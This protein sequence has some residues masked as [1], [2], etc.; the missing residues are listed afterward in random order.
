MMNK[1]GLNRI[2]NV[3]LTRVSDCSVDVGMIFVEEDE[4]NL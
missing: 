2:K 1:S 4:G 3:V